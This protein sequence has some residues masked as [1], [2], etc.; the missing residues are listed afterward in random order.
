MLTNE[1]VLLRDMVIRKTKLFLDSVL[2]SSTISAPLLSFK[3]NGFF[4]LRSFVELQRLI[5]A[6]SSSFEA[7]FRS[8]NDPK[9]L[10]QGSLKERGEEKSL[11]LGGRNRLRGLQ[12]AVSTKKTMKKQM[13]LSTDSSPLSSPKSSPTS[14]EK[15]FD[16]PIRSRPRRPPLM[17]VKNMHR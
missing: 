7:I 4:F 13:S 2:F 9:H 1:S 14:K 8:F 5:L 17:L 11:K 10:R 12:S 6:A 15:H 3:L 16:S